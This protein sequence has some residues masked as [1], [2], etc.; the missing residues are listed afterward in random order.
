[1]DRD[2]ARAHLIGVVRLEIERLE[3]KAQE[4]QERT[5]LRTELAPNLAKFDFSHEG[6]L[7]ARYEFAWRRLMD[8]STKELK[9]LREERVKSGRGHSNYYL[10]PSEGW[11]VP[12]SDESDEP[13]HRNDDEVHEQR[14]CAGLTDLDEA[15]AG[16]DTE[17]PSP[18]VK[19]QQVEAARMGVA[20]VLRNEPKDVSRALEGT[21]DDTGARCET[22]PARRRTMMATTQRCLCVRQRRCETNPAR[23]SRV[24]RRARPATPRTVFCE[25]NPRR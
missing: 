14:G 25:T 15:T 10:P 9:K 19:P 22:N 13:H 12:E 24:T 1:M 2:S 18:A 7:M 17:G 16:V 8:R 6:L 23:F 3:E 4:H 21:I 5:E 20:A 11:L